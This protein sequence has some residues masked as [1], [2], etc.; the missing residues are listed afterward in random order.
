MSRLRGPR[1]NSP[2]SPTLVRRIVAALFPRVPDEPALPP[3]LQARAIVP[4]VTMEELRGACRRIKDHTAQRLVLLPKPGKPPEEPSSYRPLC[5][6]DTAGKILERPICDRLEAITE[7]PGGLSDYQYGFRKRRSTINAIENVIATAQEAI[8]GKRWN[9]G[10]K[11]YCAVVTLDVKNA[12]NS[13]RWNNIHAALRQMHVPEYLLRIIRSYLSARLLDYDTD[14][15]PETHRVTAGVPQGSVCSIMSTPCIR[16]L[17]L[18]IDSRLR[19]DQHLRIVSEK[20]ARV[21]GALTKIMPNI[22]SVHRQACLRV[23]SGRPHVSYDMTH[24]RAGVPTL[25][26]LA[27]ERARIYQRRPEDVKEEGRRETLNRKAGKLV[28]HQN[29]VANPRCTKQLVDAL[30]RRAVVMIPRADARRATARR[31]IASSQTSTTQRREG[32]T[33]ES[34]IGLSE[35]LDALTSS[36]TFSA[37]T[38]AS[39][40][41]INNYKLIYF[42]IE[43]TGLQEAIACTQESHYTPLPTVSHFSRPKDLG[44]S[45]DP[46]PEGSLWAAKKTRITYKRSI[47]CR[48]SNLFISS[49]KCNLSY[50]RSRINMEDIQDALPNA[51]NVEFQR[52]EVEVEEIEEHEPRD[53][54]IVPRT[55]AKRAARIGE[56]VVGRG[57]RGR[58]I[59]G[60][61]RG[62]G[63][64]NRGQR[65]GRGAR[66][67]RG[68]R[69]GRGRGQN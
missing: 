30:L 61:V 32:I 49:L 12:F 4:A 58:G 60:R 54:E 21:A 42:D 64:G 24:V 43:T 63:Q 2:S 40:A 3:P 65:G 5:M 28:P 67:G 46:L 26:L 68:G 62:R 8:A 37:C 41:N 16:Y 52:D 23:I 9:R 22:E 18:Y 35:E 1:A 38:Q 55:A 27:D 19:F 48:N 14:D 56:A 57:G 69:G 11:K 34:S 36:E 53:R 25:A 17:G 7:S 47:L 6:L 66:G 51:D 59:R 13:A 33:Y 20:A 39:L 29:M 44:R 31:V 15:G 45:R 50:G 10:T